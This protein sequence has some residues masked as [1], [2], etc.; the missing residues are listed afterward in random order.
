[1][2]QEEIFDART[3]IEKLEL[4]RSERGYIFRGLPKRSYKLV[5]NAF[6]P[7][8]LNETAEKFSK[9]VP[10]YEFESWIREALISIDGDYKT[11]C[12]W[13][14]I[15][16]TPLEKI[17]ILCIYLTQYNHK[18][19]KYYE[20][21]S[22]LA[23]EDKSAIENRNSNFWEMKSNFLAMVKDFFLKAQTIW[24]LKGTI[25]KEECFDDVTSLDE[26]FPQHYGGETAAL[27]WSY[28]P[29]IALYFALGIHNTHS[30]PVM[31]CRYDPAENIYILE[32]NFN[33][34]HFSIV[35]YK[36]ISEIGSPIIRLESSI[37]KG[38]VRAERQEGTF[39]YFKN[40]CSFYKREGR[41]PAVEDY[42]AGQFFEMVRYNVQR[43]K[44]VVTF[45]IALLEKHNINKSYL[46]PD[47]KS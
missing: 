42:D 5:A 15:R 23:N 9:S 34:G 25:L 33:I 43:N 38:N 29:Y 14:S 20:S 11:D 35:A 19:S 30:S 18:L 17:L 36:Q 13:K 2:K 44:Q 12:S 47:L 1:M 8:T 31:A 27:D 6:R 16:G 28:N 41:F 4:L 21:N 32:E 46:F 7:C 24:D 45:L 22:S 10:L 26:T 37:L 3:L 40:P 39:T